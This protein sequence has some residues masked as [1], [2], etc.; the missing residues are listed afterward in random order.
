MKT[1][2]NQ[3]VQKI[4]PHGKGMKEKRFALMLPEEVVAGFGWTEDEVPA[5][6]RDVLVMALLRRHG[7]S[8][9]KAAELLHLNLKDLFEMM[10]QYQVPTIDLTPE[11]LQRALHTD[12]EQRQEG[13]LLLRWDR[14]RDGRGEDVIEGS[15]PGRAA[16]SMYLPHPNRSRLRQE[17][18]RGAGSQR[19]SRQRM[20]GTGCAPYPWLHQSS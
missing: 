8:Q 6:V 1:E 11:E 16:S 15:I 13:C 4:S 17:P 12:F 19:T 20:T 2:S 5:R 7:I 9:R 18:T 3:T 10:G 14:I